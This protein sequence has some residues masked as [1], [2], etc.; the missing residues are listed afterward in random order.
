[1]LCCCSQIWGD[2][3]IPLISSLIGGGLTLIGV[4]I[5]IRHT[6]K[7]IRNDFVSKYKPSF[8]LRNPMDDF[9]FKYS[10]PVM[11]KG[12]NCG[13]NLKKILGMFTN[14]D[15]ANF[16]IDAI[17]INGEYFRIDINRYIAKSEDF[18][19]ALCID[20]EL[21]VENLELKILDEQNI[22]YRYK[23]EFKGNEKGNIEITNFQ[24]L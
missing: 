4:I 20:K 24:N 21:K 19:F 3:I 14:T 10:K 11:F 13:E 1:M 8:K 18:D 7:T 16:E 12:G 15:K 2:I 22:V 17:Y 9:D 5:T 23:L 6:N